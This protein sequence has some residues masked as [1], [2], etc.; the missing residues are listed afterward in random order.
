MSDVAVI[1]GGAS[2]IGRAIATKLAD[3]YI[4]VL[5]DINPDGLQEVEKDLA[6]RGCK[7]FSV[8]GDVS[9]RQTHVRARVMAEEIGRL[10]AWVNCAGLTREAPLHDFPNDPLFL[11]DIIGINQ[12]GSLWGCAE[13][14]ASF[15]QGKVAGS[16]VKISS[17]H[18]RRAWR[19]HAVYEM[20]KSAI[21]ALTRNIA[22]TY[23]PYGI[24]AKAVAPGAVMTPALKQAFL[25][26]EDSHERRQA[27]ERLTP[28]KRI[29]NPSEIAEVVI[30]LLSPKASYVSGQSVGVEGG[31]TSAL[32][33]GDLDYDLAKKYGLR[34]ENGLPI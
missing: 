34:P 31:W 29:A 21:D 27:L 26:A 6:S 10:T 32:G 3:D 23:G 8:L 12:V 19:N 18:G 24:R 7:I 17:V 4:V 30:F 25:E 22:I 1:T 13:A 2:G 33:I 28:L 16:I 5:V 14:V 20:T 11:E 15:T 9:F